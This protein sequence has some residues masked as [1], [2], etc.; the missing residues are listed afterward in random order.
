MREFNALRMLPQTVAARSVG[1]RTIVEKLVA[2][3]R[4]HDF[5]DGERRFGYGGLVDD[6]RWE[7]VAADMVSTYGLA[8]GDSVLQLQCEKGFLLDSFRRLGMLTAGT[9]S[10]VY[11][12][13]RARHH[14]LNTQPT[15]IP[16]SDAI[17]DL[18]I[19]IG[20]VYTMSL[21]GAVQVLREL[22]RLARF[23]FVTLA[24]YDSA[25]DLELMRRW[26][27]L[28]T[29]FLK[30]EEWVEVMR[31][32]NYTGDYAFVSAASLGLEE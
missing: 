15:S 25:T 6:G 12:A 19:A 2:I 21:S 29:T 8:R 28:G 18:A 4:A 30:R 14:V 26:S 11:A 22:K 5:F 1:E 24:T 31:H 17:F 27:L 3:A 9:E 23:S 10:S 13:L 32:A 20:P 7:P 16:F